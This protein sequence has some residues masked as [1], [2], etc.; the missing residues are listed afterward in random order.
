MSEEQRKPTKKWYKNWPNVI[1]LAII[2]I[3][4]IGLIWVYHNTSST[5]PSIPTNVAAY[6]SA[7]TEIQYAITIYQ[8]K[9][10]GELP[11]LNSSYTNADC[12]Q[13]EIVN[14]SAL[15][16]ANGGMLRET[17]D[18]CNLSTS[19]MDNCGGNASLGCSNYGSYIW[20]VDTHGNVFS[21]CAGTGCETN[22]SGY[23]GVWP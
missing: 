15:L 22:N 20:I 3:V 1:V 12:S 10:D 13:C 14:M 23:Q 19:G 2:C 16:A 6:N 17:P 7:K 21:Y 18:S 11:T 8:N 9:N 5:G 4:A